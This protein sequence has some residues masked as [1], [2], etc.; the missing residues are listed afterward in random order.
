MMKRYAFF[1]NFAKMDMTKLTYD[2]YFAKQR[3]IKVLSMC[4]PIS[5]IRGMS[6]QEI[7]EL[8]GQSN[9]VPVD[10]K[11]VLKKLKI[12][13]LPFD[14]SGPEVDEVKCDRKDQILG[15]LVTNGNNAAIFCRIEDK[16]NSH[17]YRFTI[18]H[19]L[20][21]CCLN[22]FP[23][24]ASTIH[25][26]FR[27]DGDAMDEK[28]IAAN[29]FAGELLIPKDSLMSVI[30]ELLVPSVRALADIFDVSQAVL[31]GRLKYLK[32]GRKIIGYN[33]EV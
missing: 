18:A 12:S 21:H 20:G 27:K 8:C 13:C 6:A 3:K 30:D 9:N 33:C 4:R 10:I 5:A 17:R 28:E 1:Q 15:A 22:H 19:E 14:F 31:I 11:A 25:L 16:E 2:M 7:L 32:I 26:V 23:V 29:I 24:D